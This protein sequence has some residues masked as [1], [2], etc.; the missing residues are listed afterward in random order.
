M[1]RLQQSSVSRN[2]AFKAALFR[3]ASELHAIYRGCL[4]AAVSRSPRALDEATEEDLMAAVR[5]FDKNVLPFHRC[6]WLRLLAELQ[7]H[8]RNYAEAASCWFEV[9][10][11][12][13]AAKAL[14]DQ[15][16]DMKPFTRWEDLKRRA[17]AHTHNYTDYATLVRPLNQS[18]MAADTE[19]SLVT[20]AELFRLAASKKAKQTFI[21]AADLFARRFDDDGMKRAYMILATLGKNRVPVLEAHP[22]SPKISSITGIALNPSPHAPSECGTFYRVYFHGS[23]PDELVGAEYVYRAAGAVGIEKVRAC[24]ERKTRLDVRG[25]KD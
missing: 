5:C 9:F 25:A 23:A 24:E 12:L 15:L 20:A 7:E 11:T 14:R 13:E 10:R 1:E 8:R 19:A 18:E 17:G 6:H 2:L 21:I 16:W 22:E 4:A 3:F